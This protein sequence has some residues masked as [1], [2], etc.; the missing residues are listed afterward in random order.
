MVDDKTSKR[1]KS[2]NIIF[3]FCLI[4]IKGEPTD[5]IAGYI[6]IT[7]YKKSEAINERVFHKI[8]H[9]GLFLSTEIIRFC[10]NKTWLFTWFLLI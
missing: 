8:V 3:S 5:H 9:S 7:Q 4:W 10:S 2:L 6:V 1:K